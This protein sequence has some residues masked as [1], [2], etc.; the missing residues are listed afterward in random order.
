[1]LIDADFFSRL[2]K[3]L[4]FDPLLIQYMEVAHDIYMRNKPDANSPEVSAENMPNYKGTRS[5]PATNTV[6]LLTH[7]QSDNHTVTNVPIMFAINEPA[8]PQKLHHTASA[9]AAFSLTHFN[10]AIYGFGSGHFHSTCLSRGIPFRIQIAADA[11]YQGRNFFKSFCKTPIIVD[12]A[13]N[14]LKRIRTD[15]IDNLHGYYIESLLI[16][17]SHLQLEFLRTQSTI[18]QEMRSRSRLQCFILQIPSSY[19]KTIISQFLR[20][21]EPEGWS[22]TTEQIN[23][24]AIGD[25]IDQSTE[26]YI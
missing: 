23:F 7:D 11:T 1:M 15:T 10:G 12:S 25:C 2:K 8:K 24:A 16:H 26:I 3:N 6:T 13:I 14:L 5:I 4:Q 20:S 19:H 17:E 22:V 18:I 21:I 9:I